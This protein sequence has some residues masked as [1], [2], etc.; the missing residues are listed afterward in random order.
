MKNKR[1]I[2]KLFDGDALVLTI[3]DN[4][5]FAEFGALDRGSLTTVTEW[6]IYANR[7]SFSFVDTQGFFNNTSINKIGFLGY[8]VKFYLAYG[9]AEN[10]VGTFK[11]ESATLDDETKEVSVECV[12]RLV[13]LQ[14]KQLEE[15]YPF[16]EKN[17][18]TIISDCTID[19]I[20]IENDQ[21][22][23]NNTKIYCPYF[24]KESAWDRLN[25]ICQATMCRIYDDENGNPVISG[26]FPENLSSI[27]INPNNIL[28][29]SSNDF[30]RVPNLSIEATNR[31]RKTDS[32]IDGINDV[33]SI[34]Y[35]E[36]DPTYPTDGFGN[37]TTIGGATFSFKMV[38]LGGE[39]YSVWVTYYKTFN[40]PVKATGSA[41]M[42]LREYY[43]APDAPGVGFCLK[44]TLT[45]GDDCHLQGTDKL[46]YKASMVAVNFDGANKYKHRL[47]KIEVS[48]RADHFVD[49]GT[50]SKEI[51]NDPSYDKLRIESNDLIQSSS[52]FLNTDGSHTALGDYI[53]QEVDRRYSD[54]I[55][56]FEIECLFNDYYNEEKEKV[57]SGDDLS[58]RFKKYDVVYPYVKR[59]GKIVP[60]RT[61]QNGRRK[62]FR[63]IGISYYY[64]GL[65]RQRLQ[66]QEEK[67]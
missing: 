64:D 11:V 17:I 54:G 58:Q 35:A 36:E 2:A 19:G 39:P 28:E 65:L 29:I 45:S 37:E 33:Y 43:Q 51:I 41:E 26:S 15:N 10:I 13:D 61:S 50:E 20:I 47:Y 18:S 9:S 24:P 4:L 55:E 60:L 52:Y 44:S 1:L 67:N 59:A 66:L 46:Y 34:G 7:G 49:N 57:F 38:T 6:G 42:L 31:E 8:T 56:C 25:K 30:V 14:K 48:A 63:L 32:R 5:S 40:L 23:I 16:D 3:D 62:G 53:L 21:K 12:S 27:I 22:N